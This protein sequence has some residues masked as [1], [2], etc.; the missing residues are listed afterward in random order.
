MVGCCIRSVDPKDDCD[1]DHNEHPVDTLVDVETRDGK[2][3]SV[4]AHGTSR[5]VGVEDTF[6]AVQ[7]S[8]EEVEADD[9]TH[10]IR[11]EAHDTT[12]RLHKV[13]KHSGIHNVAVVDNTSVAVGVE[14]FFFPRFV[15][16]CFLA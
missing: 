3:F 2:N 9:D 15:F 16:V 6:L 13:G 5:A 7:H 11:A 1:T 12:G 10:R 14:A 4:E 8:A